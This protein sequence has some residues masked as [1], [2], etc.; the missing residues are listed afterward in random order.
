MYSAV[1]QDAIRYA[2]AMDDLRKA[3]LERIKK[4]PERN[5]P[6]LVEYDTSPAGN[7][8]PTN[9]YERLRQLEQPKSKAVRKA[10]L[11][12]WFK[13]Q[14]VAGDTEVVDEGEEDRE[15]GVAGGNVVVGSQEEAEDTSSQS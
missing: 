10:R 9:A 13:E 12:A 7:E 5:P 6:S 1:A 2:V 4:D 15:G 11:D 3:E 14:G 8:A